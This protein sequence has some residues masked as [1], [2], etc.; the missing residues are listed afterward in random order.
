MPDK[1]IL[2]ACCGGRMFWFDKHQENT[3]Y[4]DNREYGPEKLVNRATLEVKPD[5]VADFRAMPFEDSTFSLVV[6]DPPHMFRVGDNSYMAKKYG[7]LDGETW[8]DDIKKG[9]EECM[10]VLKPQG[11]LIFKWN[12]TR[13]PVGEVLKLAPVQP[14][15]GNRANGA[16]LKTHWLVFMK[17][18]GAK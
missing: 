5:I 15:F 7:K 11:V 3:I 14:L 17:M 6:F 12:E 10:R 4:M 9:F 1:F 13:I 2:D 18:E 16:N 8:R